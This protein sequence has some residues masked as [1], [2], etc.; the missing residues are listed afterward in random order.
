MSNNGVLDVGELRLAAEPGVRAQA[1]S[2]AP[3]PDDA[4]TGLGRELRRLLDTERG[5]VYEVVE[6]ILV[7]TAFEHCA[8]NQV[9]TAKR[10]GVSRNIVRAQLKRFGL[11][12]AADAPE[13]RT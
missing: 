8:G 3:T 10:L 11:L 6:R 12:G 5:A 2:A 7:E 1:P 9:R 13:I 4:A